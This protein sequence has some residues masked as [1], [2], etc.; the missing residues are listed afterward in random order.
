LPASAELCVFDVPALRTSDVLA[1][2]RSEGARVILTE[3]GPSVMSQLVADAALDEL[4]LT[5]SPALFGRYPGDD[6]KGLTAG[7]NL[8]RVPL[9]LLSVRRA[10]S[11]LFLRYAL[12]HTSI[13]LPAP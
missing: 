12:E 2:L 3:G 1:R 10:G 9:E 13:P 5:V 8:G 7:L 11:H 6:R 4:F